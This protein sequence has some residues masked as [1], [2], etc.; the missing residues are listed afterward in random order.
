MQAVIFDMDGVILES[1]PLHDSAS[2]DVFE[3]HGFGNAEEIES[4]L[5]DFRGSTDS[6]FWSCIKEKFSIEESLETLMGW[7]EERFLDIIKESDIQLMD[8]LPS[9]LALLHDRYPLALASSSSSSAI[10]AIVDGLDVRTYFTAIVSGD[11]IEHSKPAPD[12]FLLAAEKLG[13][14]PHECIVIEDSQNGVR[15]GNAAGMHTIGYYGSPSNRQDLSEAA[16]TIHHYDE[17]AAIL[18]E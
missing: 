10:D 15:A 9:V 7:K 16:V 18:E 17:I 2:C 4:L 1:E 14:D 6:A 3:G 8:G 13:V 5:N 11:D 12:I